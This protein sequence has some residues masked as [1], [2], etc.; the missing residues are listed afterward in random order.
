MKTHKEVTNLEISELFRALAASL[1]LKNE[2]SNKFRIIAYER[3]ADAVEHLSSEAKDLWD[4]GKLEEIPGIGKSMAE[5]LGE[6]FKKG[7]SSHFD[8][9]LKGIPPSVFKLMQLPRVG[10]KTA[11]KLVHFLSLEH[12]KDPISSLEKACKEGKVSSLEGFGQ[13]SQ[14]DLLLAIDE[15]RRFVKRHLLPY[16]SNLADEIISW[17]KEDKSVLEA[18][19]LGSLRR[20][21]STVGDIDMAISTNEP[22]KV[23]SRFTQ[24]P[25]KTR[26]IEKGDKTASILLPG[27]V[28]VD[29]MVGNPVL[30]GSLLQHFTGSKHHN[31]KLREYAIKKNMSL[32]EYGIKVKEG[33]N[34]TTKKFATEKSFYNFLS[35]EFIPP[36][37]RE[38]AGEI[39]LAIEDKLPKLI[40]V[41]DVLGDLQI[42][43]NFDTQTSHDVGESSISEISKKAL[44]LGYE[45]V[46]LTDHNPSV[47]NHKEK[48]VLN[49][50]KKR[51]E[52]I[53]E[54][55]YSAKNNKN[56]RVIFIF[57]SLEID[58]LQDGELAISDA[59]LNLLDFALV[60][61]HS[62]FRQEKKTA[63]K[64]VLTALSHPKVKIFAHPTGR[65]L[66]Q[67]EGIELDWNEIFDFC[68][69]NNKILE[70]NADPAR[71]DLPD[72]LVREGVARGV[73]FSL[74]TDSHHKDHMDNMRWGVSVARR[75]W[76]KSDDIVNCLKL[77]DFKKVIQQS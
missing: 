34:E 33:S 1:E 54:Y 76:L 64:R 25:K 42:H 74:G 6:V 14:K 56:N 26:I 69:K 18:Y 27:G 67:R 31:I 70:I 36:E 24:Y 37:L 23:L 60:S 28:Q 29:L 51:R 68:V 30:F 5:S 32:S 13:E 3:A 57:N 47:S 50:L 43:S 44:E 7:T 59:A 55:N 9:I 16:A 20:M 4:E 15:F 65:L 48:D 45:Y 19:A 17:M 10:A 41:A 71:L 72:F 8:E 52:K 62:S 53:E 49:I 61:I 46:A 12:S 75:G 40:E 73:K 22:Q 2:K 35:M 66:N 38:D 63:T 11:S 21:A 58:I 77:E 39:E